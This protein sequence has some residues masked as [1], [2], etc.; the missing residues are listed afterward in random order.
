[1]FTGTFIA[2]YLFIHPPAREINAPG[3]R[4]GMID[5]GQHFFE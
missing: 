3:G 1:M 2:I 4:G 5:H